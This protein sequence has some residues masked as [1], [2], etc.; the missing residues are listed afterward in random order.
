[1]AT[2]EYL[3]EAIKFG[4]KAL[5]LAPDNYQAHLALGGAY[6][7]KGKY[8]DSFKFLEKALQLNS[9][10]ADLEKIYFYIG[11]VYFAKDLVANAITYFEKIAEQG[12][13]LPAVYFILAICY[14]KKGDYNTAVSLYKKIIDIDTQYNH[15]YS[16]LGSAYILMKNYKEAI[17][18]FEKNMGIN[19]KNGHDLYALG[20]CYMSEGEYDK[21][22]DYLEEA[23]RFSSETDTWIYLSLG[24]AY[25]LVNYLSLALDCYGEVLSQ[26]DDKAL[27]YYRRAGDLLSIDIYRQIIAKEVKTRFEWRSTKMIPYYLLIIVYKHQGA[28]DIAIETCQKILAVDP[29][30]GLASFLLAELH[31]AQKSSPQVAIDAYKKVLEQDSQD[32][33]TMIK[34]VKLYLEQQQYDLALIYVQKALAVN[35]NNPEVNFQAGLV[36]WKKELSY[37][38]QPLLGKAVELAPNNPEAFFYLGEVYSSL[39]NQDS[40]RRAWQKAAE[41]APDS[42]FGMEANKRLQETENI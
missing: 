7:K 39:R 34:L 10:P 38:A 8:D 5:E 41:L 6:L 17:S 27:K 33:E 20:A 19:G 42:Q 3:E 23:L 25:H 9:D 4:Q 2:K 18:A 11:E 30:D 16:A 31:T 13:P 37:T 32:I 22:I 40:A 29:S 15:V 35:S 21:A 14:R 24:S 36:Y 1:M 26:G 28:Y 12:S